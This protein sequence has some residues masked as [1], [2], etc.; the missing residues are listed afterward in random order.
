MKIDKRIKSFFLAMVMLLASW[1]VLL[2]QDKKQE[3]VV[4]MIKNQQYVFKAQTVF[5]A[6]ARFQQLNYDYD[7]KIS[8]DTMQSYLPYFGRAYTA[9][10]DQTKGTLDFTSTKFEYQVEDRKKGGW[11]IT[12]KPKD[13]R[14]VQQY[15]FTIQ[16]NGSATLRVLSNNRQPISFNGYITRKD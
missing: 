1:Q 16:E 12:V 6:P 8:K 15:Y 10:I 4:E 2:A 7:V 11:N 9:P 13:N 3:D 14:E 5:P